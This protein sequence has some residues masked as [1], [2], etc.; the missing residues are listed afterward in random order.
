MRL[1]EVA[2]ATAP[3][4]AAPTPEQQKLIARRKKTAKRMAETSAALGVAA[5]AAKA[6]NYA[7]AVARRAPKMPGAKRIAAFAPKAEKVSEHLVPLSIGV[8]AAGSLNYARQ[9]RQDEKIAAKPVVT[10]KAD[11]RFLRQHRNYISESAERAYQDLGERRERRQVDR[12]AHLALAGAGAAAATNRIAPGALSNLQGR[13]INA[14]L[15]RKHPTKMSLTP[16]RK[17]TKF[18]LLVG[19]PTAAGSVQ[20]GRRAWER[21]KEANSLQERREKIKAKAYERQAAGQYGRPAALRKEHVDD[22]SK[23]L[24]KIPTPGIRRAPRPGGLMRMPTGKIVTRRG[25]IPGTGRLF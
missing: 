15:L 18:G 25:A 1:S 11:D 8:G 10:R 14:T 13:A 9:L 3:V 19:L 5:L 7:A 20:L 21:Q 24:W 6:P 23:A 12:S 16:I 22:V 4:V 17:P 2:K